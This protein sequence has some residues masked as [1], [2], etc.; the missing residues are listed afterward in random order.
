MSSP[1]VRRCTAEDWSEIRR[2]HINMALG[3]PP[4]VDVE[5]N[6]VLGT[7]NAFWESFVTTGADD[8]R[9]ALFVADTGDECVGMGH[10]RL[11]GGEA[12]LSML[13]VEG[14]HRRRGVGSDLVASQEAWAHRAGV[15]RLAAHIPET[16]A[17]SQLAD[18]L[19]WRQEDDVFF[20]MHGLR[21]HRW[22]RELSGPPGA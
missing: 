5:P 14:S 6:E 8:A 9:Q 17:A 1:V 16:S 11:E 10:V 21:E 22:T 20:T 2:L 7:P 18:K 3:L 15:R 4:V 19:G 12:Q 13:F